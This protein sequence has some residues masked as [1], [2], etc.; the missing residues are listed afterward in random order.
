M[1][2]QGSKSLLSYKKTVNRSVYNTGKPGSPMGRVCVCSSLIFR[3]VSSIWYMEGFL[4]GYPLTR[5]AAISSSAGKGGSLRTNTHSRGGCTSW[6]RMWVG[7]LGV[8]S[9]FFCKLKTVDYML[10]CMCFNTKLNAPCRMP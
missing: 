8:H 7:P 3:E 6:K 5:A 2:Q 1:S 4:L 9:H 10:V